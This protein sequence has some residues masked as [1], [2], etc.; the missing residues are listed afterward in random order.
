MDNGAERLARDVDV[1][2]AMSN[3]MA[4][5]L[6]SDVLFWPMGLS[7]MPMLTLGGYLMREYRLQALQDQLSAEDWARVAA[8]VSRFNEV[9]A[10]RVVRFEKK[11]G[12]E[13]EARLR[14]WQEYLKEVHSDSADR[15]A[16]YATAVE[17]RAMIDEL[18]A[19]LTMPPYRLPDRAAEY[20]STLNTVQRN[21]WQPGE[22]VW[23]ESWESAYPAADYW[24][25]YGSL[26]SSS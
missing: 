13:L 26:P 20:L 6:D 3:E 21:R 7:N 4:D 18:V 23:P 15:A 19:R 16:N 8:A 11:A 1:L 17:T 2:E 24:W 5:Y 12:A 9:L 14:Q 10:N 25:L 22:F